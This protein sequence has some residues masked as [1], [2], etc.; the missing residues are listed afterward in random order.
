MPTERPAFSLKKTAVVLLGICTAVVI[1]RYLNWI[2][3]DTT[4]AAIFAAL[5]VS[6]YVTGHQV[7]GWI[8]KRLDPLKKI[9]SGERGAE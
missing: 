9:I 7:S 2:N 6:D 4:A 5:F 1:L 3:S 8:G